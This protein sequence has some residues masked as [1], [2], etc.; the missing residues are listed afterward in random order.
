MN[1]CDWHSTKGTI[2]HI[3][4]GFFSSFLILVDASILYVLVLLFVVYQLIDACESDTSFHHTKWDVL[5]F[6]IGI[7]IGSYCI[8]LLD[9]FF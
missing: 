6:G 1:Y 3:F 8:L 4:G 7:A 2:Y 5:E 9:F